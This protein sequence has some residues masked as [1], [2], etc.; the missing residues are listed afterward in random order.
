MFTR[1]GNSWELVKASIAVLRSEKQL[2]IFPLI[3][4]I[5]TIIVTLTFLF[6]LLLAHALDRLTTGQWSDSSGFFATI[7]TLLFY[8]VNYTVIY[9]CNAALVGAVMLH[10]QGKPATVRAGFDIAFARLG[11][12]LGYA[13]I[14]ATVGMILRLIAEKMNIIG[15]III[16]LIGFAW[17]IATALV[18]PVL[19]VEDVNPIDAIK[20]SASLLK[21]TWGERLVGG[22]SMGF[23]FGLLFFGIV[24]VFVPLLII[25]GSL[26]S[27]A[28]FALFIPLC[29]LALVA[30]GLIS[31]AL[32]GIFN[33]ALYN[34]AV[35]GTTGGLYDD[36]LVKMAF[37]QKR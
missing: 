26:K 17:A 12:I 33:A 24:I 16:S 5:G 10:L 34:Y 28:L 22:A 14:S 7:I 35:N 31:S 27:V 23:I 8:I 37:K 19:V 1:I 6:P 20:R 15:K 2:I 4:M 11:N 21:E 13:L 25:A 29:V 18:V 9:F 3:S 30:M 32:Q 36:N